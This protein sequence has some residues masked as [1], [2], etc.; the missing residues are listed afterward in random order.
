ME[1]SEPGANYIK[2]RGAQIN[3]AN[4]FNH[5]VHDPEPQERA[6]RTQ[7]IEVF[8]KTMLNRVTSP[9]IGMGWS[10]NPYQGCE[11]GCIYCYAR[12]T[13]NYWGYS[14]GLDFEQKILVKKDAPRIL[15]EELRKKSWKPEPI[16]LA[17]NTDCYQPVEKE[18]EVTRRILEILWKYRHPVGIITKNSLILRDLDILRQM[19]EHRLVRTSIS[20][21]TL[22]EGLRRTLEPRTA[23]VH[24]RLKTIQTLA[25]N[26]IPVNVMLAPIIPGLNDHEI[27]SMAETVSRLGAL[28]IGYTMVRLNGDVAEIFEDWIRKNMPDR[29]ERVLNRIRDCHGGELKDNRFG[30]RMRGEGKIAEIVAQQFRLAKQQYFKDK[31]KPEYNL[32]LFEQFRNPQLSLFQPG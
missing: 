4:R 19:S 23:S 2:G 25:E 5:Y 13:H 29:A 16:M 6:P 11:H 15:E 17:G 24:N 12:N 10:M 9:D 22:D 7:Y 3:P 31:E 28:S 32:E 8:P 20:L 1:Y 21:T 26:G 18:L 30:T 27:L 14:A